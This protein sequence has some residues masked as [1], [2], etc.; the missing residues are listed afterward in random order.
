MNR[1]PSARPEFFFNAL[2]NER[3]FQAGHLLD[4]R[5][6]FYAESPGALPAPRRETFRAETG[7]SSAAPALRVGNRLLRAAIPGAVNDACARAGGPF[8][9]YLSASAS[10][11]SRIHHGR[12][13]CCAEL[14]MDGA[15]LKRGVVVRAPVVTATRLSVGIHHAWR[16]SGLKGVRSPDACQFRR[17]TRARS[18]YRD[19]VIHGGR[20]HKTRAR[21]PIKRV[22]ALKRATS[23]SEPSRRGFNDASE[24]E[25]VRPSTERTP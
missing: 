1:M 2:T 12:F 23:P 20:A 17:F 25:R 22:Q 19:G 8:K 24:T 15:R 9:G 6:P 21:L 16:P 13:Q 5:L 11:S 3:A 10:H 14:T 7:P 18:G 4:E